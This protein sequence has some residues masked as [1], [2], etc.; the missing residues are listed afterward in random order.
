MTAL[1]THYTASK[2]LVSFAPKSITA[3]L[4][5]LSVVNCSYDSSKCWLANAASA[6]YHLLLGSLERAAAA[7]VQQ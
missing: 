5:F 3:R 4:F 1:Q 2:L 6:V 7:A